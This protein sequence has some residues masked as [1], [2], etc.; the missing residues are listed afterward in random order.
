M[1]LI[2][3]PGTHAA[4]EHEL[5]ANLAEIVKNVSEHTSAPDAVTIVG[6]VSGGGTT[7]S[8]VVGSRSLVTPEQT[9]F[10]TDSV[11]P[12]RRVTEWE[13]HHASMLVGLRTRLGTDTQLRAQTATLRLPRV[14]VAKVNG[15][16]HSVQRTA[17]D[18]AAHPVS[19]VVVYIPLQGMNEF[20][21]RTGSLTVGPGRGLICDGDTAFSRTF[22]QGVSELVVQLPRETLAQL[23]D[24]DSVRRPMPLDLDPNDSLNPAARELTQ[25]AAGALDRG[26]R[27]G[28]RLETRLLDLLSGV[29][30]RPLANTG[31]MQEAMAVIAESHCD[32]GLN[33]SRLAQFLGVSERQL[34]RLFSATGRSVPQTISDARLTTARRML[35]DPSR[36]NA[37]MVEIASTCGFGSQAQLSRGYRR[38]FGIGPLRHRKQLLEE[39]G[40]LL[41][42]GGSS[43][44]QRL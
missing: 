29:L 25:L 8:A 2:Q 39:S 17:D 12:G 1:A 4:R 28:Q 7:A 6:M 18:V 11:P 13:T 35:A 37:P 20:R 33:A 38:R 22:P 42:A 3:Q 19:G 9:W 41:Q 24:S 36:A 30:S 26:L 32:P 15:S 34:S 31:P 5:A 16:P 27:Q 21:H 40:Q 14:R 23:T 43:Y 44:C 10:S